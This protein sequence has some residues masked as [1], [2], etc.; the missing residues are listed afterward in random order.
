MSF[1]D[2]N[3]EPDYITRLNYP[4][5]LVYRSR[6]FRI[7]K[8]ENFFQNMAAREQNRVAATSG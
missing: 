1:K 6:I 2:Y 8:G 5:A 7:R 3:P 4:F